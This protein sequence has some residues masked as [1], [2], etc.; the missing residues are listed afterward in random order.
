MTLRLAQAYRAAERTTLADW[1]S[2]LAALATNGKIALWGAGA[3]GATLANLVDPQCRW[4]EA[5]VD[6]N[7]A[8]QG[9]Y[10]PGTGH[11]II[12]PRELRERHI[13]CAVLMNPNY[14]PEVE[15]WRLESGIPFELIDWRSS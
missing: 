4:I 1:E 5:L 3:K 15:A 12:A 10:V 6:V 11:P 9:R 13:R 8:K 2:R 7:P 14:R